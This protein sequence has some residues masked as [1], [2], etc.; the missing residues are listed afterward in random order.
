[1]APRGRHD[2]VRRRISLIRRSASGILGTAITG[3][4]FPA[5][6]SQPA[7]IL[8]TRG[9]WVINVKEQHRLRRV[10]VR[11]QLIDD[12]ESTSPARRCQSVVRT[13]KSHMSRARRR[14]VPGHLPSRRQRGQ[15]LGIPLLGP[16]GEV[17]GHLAALDNRSMPEDPAVLA[18][19][20]I[21]AARAAA[22][23][24]RQQAES[25]LKEHDRTLQSLA[26]EA[27]YFRHELAALQGP[28]EIIG[29]SDA[30][31]R[32][33]VDAR[34]VA[35]TDTTVLVLGETGTGKELVARAIH[36][37]SKR[38]KAPFIKVNLGRCPTLD[39]GE[40]FGHERR[41][42]RGHARRDG[43]FALA[44]RSTSSSM[45]SA[46]CLCRCR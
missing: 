8:Q 17:L 15:L 42:H 37:A 24:R 11:R 32:T 14:V 33:L 26:N 3:R 13:G 39:R 29:Q 7:E 19:F 40:L 20:Q 30:L 28:F 18:V 44:D 34:Q 45:K 41:V 46:T 23:L 21:F 1:M 38:P 31:R 27:E 2:R 35:G 25:R 22:E 36:A 12:Y 9:V 10:L 6:S 5:S 16:D 4:R 43:Q